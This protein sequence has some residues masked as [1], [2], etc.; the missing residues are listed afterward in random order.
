MGSK[1][2]T[3]VPAGFGGWGKVI[4]WWEEVRKHSS[5]GSIRGGR[6]EGRL[7]QKAATELGMGLEGWTWG[8]RG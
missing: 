5:V 3:Q 7:P 1:E 4:S 6:E 2:P 8:N